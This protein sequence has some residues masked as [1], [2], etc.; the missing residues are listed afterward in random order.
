M[1]KSRF[2]LP[3]RYWLFI[4]TVICVGF[5]AVGFLKPAF[6]GKITGMVTSVIM[7]MQKGMSSLSTSVSEEAGNVTSLREAQQE[8]ENL[9][10]ENESLKAELEKYEA[11]QY[12]LAQLKELL[13]LKDEYSDYDIAAARVIQKSS[14]SWFNSFVINLGKN[15]GIEENMNVISGGGL[16]G[17]VTKVGDNYARVEAIIDD[18]SSVSAMSLNSGDYCVVTGSLELYEKGLIQLGYIDKNDNVHDGDKIVTSNISDKYL[19]GLLIGYAKD[20]TVDSNNLTKS[21]YVVPVADFENLQ[22]VLVIKTLKVT[23]GDG[24][25]G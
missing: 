24:N 2:S 14:G 10:A 17:I 25:E 7:P 19:P 6:V 15:D 21:G 3:P 18:M 12:E 9:R 23:G 22:T 20:I 13:S 5:L 8:N 11:D 16:A 4:I 1:K